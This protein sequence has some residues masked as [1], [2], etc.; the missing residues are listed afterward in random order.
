MGGRHVIFSKTRE[1]HI[2]EIYNNLITSGRWS[3]KDS[4]ILALVG[5][6]HKLVDDTKKSSKNSNMNNKESISST[7]G[8]LEYIN[9]LPY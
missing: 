1:G 9:F 3:T 5:V 6:V 2:P 7:K 4:N 8:E